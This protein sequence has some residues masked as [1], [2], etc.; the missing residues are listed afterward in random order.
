MLVVGL[1]GGTGAGKSIVASL[2]AKHGYRY[3]SADEVYRALSSRETE[4]TRGI[5]A[6]FGAR[7]VIPGGGIDRKY[8]ASLV[9][10]SSREAAENLKKLDRVTHK[11]VTAEMDKLTEE[12]AASGSRSVIIDAP[13][14]FESGYDGKCD[15]T[16][17]VIA[18]TERR[19]QR[20]TDRDGLTRGDAE[21]RIAAQ[22]PDGFFRRRC[23]YIIDNDGTLDTLTAKTELVIAEIDGRYR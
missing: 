10:G 12:F 1:T 19:I 17:G 9:F 22:L 14:L 5:A 11:F 7:A 2:F 23:D 3:I 6:A 16:V 15:V 13:Q 18:D 8:I 20:L 21:R 4:C